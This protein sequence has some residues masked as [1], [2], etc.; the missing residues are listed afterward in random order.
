MTPRRRST[1]DPVAATKRWFVTHGL[2]YFVPG[3]RI[4]ARRALRLR[5]TLPLALLVGAT[6]VLAGVVLSSIFD[7]VTLGPAFVLNLTVL[8]LLLYAVTALR[9]RPLVTWALARTFHDL[10]RLLPMMSRALPLLLLFVTFLFINA[11]V[12]G[13]A[14][15]LRSGTLWLTV[16]LFVLLAVG[17]L[18]VRLPE[19][20][21]GVDDAVDEGFLRRGCAGTPLAE[22]CGRLLADPSVDPTRYAEV[23]GYERWNLVWVLVIIQAVQVFL[24]SLTV[25]VFFLCFGA[26]VMGVD[27]Q[28]AWTGLEPGAFRQEVLGGFSVPLVKVSLFLA[29]FSALHLAVSSVTDETYRAQFFGSVMTELER[30]VALRAVHRALSAAGRGVE[31]D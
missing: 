27:V 4:L 3:E 16:L 22:E 11:D 25:L 9:A 28:A 10:R 15:S 8:A 12:W 30:A 31:G 13:L 2:P 5:R 18:L 24:L 23:R 26:L 6:T 19:T 20:V 14:A 29:A 1:A 21:D 7:Q 17:F